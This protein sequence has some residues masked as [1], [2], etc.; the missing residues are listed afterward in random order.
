MFNHARTLLLNIEGGTRSPGPDFLGEELITQNFRKIELPT[1]LDQIRQ[2]LFGSRPD[3]AMYNYRAKQLLPLIHATELHEFALRLDNRITYDQAR[4]QTL[5]QPATFLP[6]INRYSGHTPDTLTLIGQPIVPDAVGQLRFDYDVDILTPTTVEVKRLT[7]KTFSVIQDF[8]LTNKLSRPLRLEGAGY[9]FFLN[10]TSPGAQWQ[11]GGYFRPQWDIGQLV[12]MLDRVGEP[13]ML[14]L[15][16]LSNDEPWVTF[17]N[18]WYD[19]HS[20]PYR[21]GGLL[22][23]MIYRTEEVRVGR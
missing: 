15:F 12:A 5:Y 17:R 14:Q 22:L 9:K 18:L 2:F 20:L 11:I 4:E 21:L 1:Y 13:V 23:A 3:R 19:H 8:S 7:P 16:G 6:Q 10:T